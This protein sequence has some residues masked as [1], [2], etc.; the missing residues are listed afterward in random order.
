[1]ANFKNTIYDYYSNV[2]NTAPASSVKTGTIETQGTAVLGTGTKFLTEIGVGGWIFVAAQSEIR[3]V[4]AI[5]SDT[6]AFMDKPF[7]ADLAALSACV[8]VSYN[9]SKAVSIAV[10]VPAG[11][12]TDISIDGKTMPK[13]TSVS[14]SKDSRD[15]SGRNDSV[16]PLIVNATGS[17]AQILIQK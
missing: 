12:A 6:K 11:A 4:V 9:D 5:E 16:D 15:I 1:M 8:A 7:T 10:Q 13:G 14:F 3:K 17:V 2:H